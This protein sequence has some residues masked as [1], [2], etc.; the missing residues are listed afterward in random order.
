MSNIGA[1]GWGA[2][3]F[4]ISFAL[5]PILGGI[6]SDTA[7]KQSSV[8]QQVYQKEAYNKA[9]V[10]FHCS[11]KPTQPGQFPT[12]ALVFVKGKNPG[13]RLA[14]FAEGW[15]AYEAKSKT[16]LLVS[17]CYPTADKTISLQK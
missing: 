8:S 1:V 7:P 11:T 13:Y 16:T 3:A 12:E 2:M 9:L 5:N 4:G 15:K 10:K 17:P 14:S 6:A